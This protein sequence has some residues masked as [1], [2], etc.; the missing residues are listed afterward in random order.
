[1]QYRRR[2]RSRIILS[3]VVLGFGL[4]ALFA[5]STLLLRARIE[6]QLVEDWLQS[7]ARAFLEFKRRN[8]APEHD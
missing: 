7:E 4:T 8:P 6:N 2:L 1:M 3:F 5:V